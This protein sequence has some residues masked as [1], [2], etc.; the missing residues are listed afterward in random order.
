LELE[1][2][3]WSKKALFYSVLTVLLVLVLD[4]WLKFYIKTNFQ[5]NQ[6][7][8]VLGDWFKLHFT[9]N[10]GMAFGW[11]L[12]GKTGKIVLTVF[13][14]IAS[15]FIVFYIRTLIKSRAKTGLIVMVSLI[16]A[17]ALGNIIDSIFYGVLFTKSTYH[18]VASFMSSEGGYAPFLMGNV[19]DMLYFPLIDT[20]LPDWVPFYGGTRFQ[21]FRPVFNLADAAIS[22]G[23]FTILIF[24]K[25]LF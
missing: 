2:S 5:F 10:E 24:R 19:V 4:Q 16:L 6:T 22:I 23:V 21:F 11:K 14:I 3:N 25:R 1:N 8:P 13:R 9:E 7:V 18:E 12:G 15:I 17:G 20:I